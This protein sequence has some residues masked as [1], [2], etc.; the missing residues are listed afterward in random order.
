MLKALKT[1]LTLS[2]NSHL[3]LSTANIVG[4][5]N[6][7]GGLVSPNKQYDVRLQG[8]QY[9]EFKSYQED[10]NIDVVQ[11]LGYLNNINSLNDLLYVFNKSKLSNQQAKDKIQ[12]VFKNNATTIFNVKPSLFTTIGIPSETILYN[13]AT[14]GLLTTHSALNFVITN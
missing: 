8:D 5:D 12:T 4:F 3:S 11:L 2:N 14:Q 1:G 6:A 13:L 9:I 7:F 10:T